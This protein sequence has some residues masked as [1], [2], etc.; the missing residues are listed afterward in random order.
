MTVLTGLP[1][2]TAVSTLYR[3]R[4]LGGITSGTYYSYAVCVLILMIKSASEIAFKPF[5]YF[6]LIV[7]VCFVGYVISHGVNNI[8]NE[9]DKSYI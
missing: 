5:V 7:P 3:L 8:D 6:S 4:A 9:T 2:R 1:M